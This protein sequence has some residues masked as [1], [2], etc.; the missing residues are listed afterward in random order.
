M[1]A[2]VGGLP[3]LPSRPAHI[4]ALG[5]IALSLLPHQPI[6]VWAYPDSNTVKGTVYIGV[7]AYHSRGV[8][9]VDMSIDNGQITSITEETVNPDTGEYEFVLTVD[10]TALTDGPH[11]IQAKA[12]PE[13]N[14][15]TAE[16]TE[17]TLFVANSVAFSTWYVDCSAADDSGDGSWANPWKSL[18]R[19]LG[20]EWET[21]NDPHANSG[22]SVLLVNDTCEY[23]LPQNKYG[24]FTQLYNK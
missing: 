1:L 2:N 3:E 19:A 17:I 15:T 22:D 4:V 13:E 9:S 18:G 10:T 20:T 14:G 24:D 6:G 12:V 21:Q 8:K 7:V 23:D 5:R 16:L 11:T